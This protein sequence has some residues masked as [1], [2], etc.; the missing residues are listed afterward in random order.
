[1]I[2]LKD[3]NNEMITFFKTSI[4]KIVSKDN[5]ITVHFTDGSSNTFEKSLSTLINDILKT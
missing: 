2:T 1:V 5:F 4:V 3:T